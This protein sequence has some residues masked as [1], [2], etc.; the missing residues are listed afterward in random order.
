MAVLITAG[1]GGDVGGEEAPEARELF[2]QSATAKGPDPF[3]ESTATA[4]SGPSTRS[5]SSSAR[6]GDSSAAPSALSAPAASGGPVRMARTL[7]SSTPGVYGVTRSRSSCDVERQVRL[8]IENRTKSRAFAEA[9]GIGRASVPSFLRELTPVVLRADTRVTNHGFR[10]GSATPFQS[11]LQAGT[12][13]LVDNHGLPRVRCACGSPLRPAVAVQGGVVHRGARWQ[14]YRPDRVVL[15]VRTAQVLGSLIVADVG[16]GVWVE[17][18]TGTYG[19]ED[20]RPDADP[21]YAPEADITDP[22]AVVPPVPEETPARPEPSG[23]DPASTPSEAPS[24][25]NSAPV[26]TE[27][28]TEDAPSS[29]DGDHETVPDDGGLYPAMPDAQ[30]TSIELVGPDTYQG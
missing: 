1:C 16:H 8:L 15:I 19:D 2:L 28:P 14:A 20:G 5:D 18:P 4:L 13:V 17:R 22:E 21:P 29:P 3:T 27:A 23:S 6:S 25:Q 9:A 24:E 26:P 30:Q 10:S 7:P 12:A 11:V